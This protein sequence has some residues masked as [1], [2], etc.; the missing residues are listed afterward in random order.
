MQESFDALNALDIK[1]APSA[2]CIAEV[3]KKGFSK[4]SLNEMY[5]ICYC[6]V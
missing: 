5:K 4:T 2:N 6:I 3:L 1:G